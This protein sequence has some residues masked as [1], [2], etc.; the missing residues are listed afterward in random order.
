MDVLE[1]ATQ[2][3]WSTSFLIH[4]GVGMPVSTSDA[5]HLLGNRAATLGPHRKVK[6][7]LYALQDAIIQGGRRKKKVTPPDNL[8]Q[9]VRNS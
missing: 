7:K 8:L 4:R 2:D 5:I 6:W 3:Y 9:L 1:Q